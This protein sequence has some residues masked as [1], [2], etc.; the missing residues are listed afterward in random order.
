MTVIDWDVLWNWTAFAKLKAAGKAAFVH[1]RW[2]LVVIPLMQRRTIVVG[3][4]A[5]IVRL[6]RRATE[7][8]LA[9]VLIVRNLLAILESCQASLHLVKLRGRD[10]VFVLRRQDLSDLI[11]RVLNAIRSCWM[12]GEGL[13]QCARFLLLCSL[14]RLSRR[15]A[16]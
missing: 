3:R 15:N 5:L 10:Y 12:R 11:L 6:V 7:R 16:V 8:R 4:L 1:S 9:R 13:G 2:D 14:D